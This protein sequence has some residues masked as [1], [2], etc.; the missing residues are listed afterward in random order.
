[1]TA[2][3]EAFAAAAEDLVGVP[4]G[5][6]GRDRD[7]RLDCVGLVAAALAAI[8]REVRPPAGYRLRQLDPGPFLDAAEMAGLE[9][10]EGRVLPGDVLLARPGPAQH[11]LLVA[12]RTGGFVHAHAGLGRVVH[13][14]APLQWPVVRRWRLTG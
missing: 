9:R 12:S 3:G 8:G 11:H 7:R 13:A 6:Y 4:F 10:A 2:A 1:M 14:P 5:L